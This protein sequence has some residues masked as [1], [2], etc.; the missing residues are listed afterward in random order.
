MRIP[1]DL[2]LKSLVAAPARSHPLPPAPTLNQ[3]F[4]LWS[5]ETLSVGPGSHWAVS[6]SY[7]PKNPKE[8]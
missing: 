7:R 3:Y 4:E 5:G 8:S 1:E 2:V 6:G